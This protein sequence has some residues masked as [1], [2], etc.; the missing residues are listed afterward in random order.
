MNTE[1]F[2]NYK[3][4]EKLVENHFSLDSDSLQKFKHHLYNQEFDEVYSAMVS[5]EDFRLKIALNSKDMESF[6]E[7]WNSFKRNFVSFHINKAITYEQ[8]IS[9]IIIKNK[10]QVKL[11]KELLNFY[12]KNED[13]YERDI[14]HGWGEAVS[15]YKYSEEAKKSY[16][17]EHIKNYYRDITGIK[18]SGK[19]EEISLVFSLNFTDWFLGSTDESWTS[20]L[21]L[22]SNYSGSYWSGLP[23]MINDKNRAL[24]YFTDGR[25]KNYHGII[26][27]RIIKRSWVIIDTED[28]FHVVRFFPSN[29]NLGL[30]S[31]K[32]DGNWSYIPNERKRF[33]SKYDLD[34]L[35]FNSG[36]SCFI[37]Q[38][39]TKL[40]RINN[41][42]YFLGAPGYGG[43]YHLNKNDNIIYENIFSFEDGLDY[44][45]ENNKEISGFL[46]SNLNKCCACGERI[47][48]EECFTVNNSNYCQH[49]YDVY[50]IE[51]YECGRITDVE[52]L[53]IITEGFSQRK[54]CSACYEKIRFTCVKCW[55]DFP[56]EEKNKTSLGPVCIKCYERL[57]E[58]E[59]KR[60]IC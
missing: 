2:S 7:G 16:I 36:D 32:L 49:C 39:N 18:F 28:I 42:L 27:E 15:Y 55:E 37:Y 47:F 51:C 26:S 57:Q 20:C 30:I 44:L 33:R 60:K 48:I 11:F 8:F 29:M 4:I 3:K 46:L 19:S 5:N 31:N 13:L 24:I 40:E 50:F 53:K 25:K 21:N 58:E 17:K 22:D 38:D 14:Y 6:D 12:I 23:G 56:V 34:F 41:K 43:Y 45:K 52:D 54:L 1:T 9:G 10:Q 35:K 59:N